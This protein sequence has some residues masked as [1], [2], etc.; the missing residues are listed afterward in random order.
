MGPWDRR[1]METT[2][3]GPLTTGRAWRP[4]H[5]S[6]N[7]RILVG[8]ASPLPMT[9]PTDSV[10]SVPNHDPTPEDGWTIQDARDLYNIEGWGDGYFDI[11]AAGRVFVRP[12][13]RHQDRTLDLY[14]LAQD[15]EAQGIPLPVLVRFSEILQSRIEALDERFARAIT[16]FEYT[17]MAPPHGELRHRIEP[18]WHGRRGC[19]VR[20]HA[21]EFRTDVSTGRMARPRC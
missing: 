15:L 16:E 5:F 10:T 1:A 2:A 13:R 21:A 18:R 11:N 17:G 4:Y 19:A 8:S 20:R 14:E 12:D 9:A 6:A 7:P 3:W